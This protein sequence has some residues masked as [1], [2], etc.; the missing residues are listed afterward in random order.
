MRGVGVLCVIGAHSVGPYVSRPLPG[1]LWP[2]YEPAAG[3]WEA[4][5]A[6]G[7]APGITD[8]VFW[9]IRA[10]TVPMFFFV[11]GLMGHQALERHGA[12]EFIRSRARKVGSALF[13]GF[14]LVMPVVYVIWVWGWVRYGYAAWEHLRHFHFGPAVQQNLHGFGHLW[15]LWYL[16]LMCAAAAGVWRVFE[17]RKNKNSGSAAFTFGSALLAA[18]VLVPLGTLS[19]TAVRVFENG[20]VPRAGF[21][22]FHAV[23]FAWGMA[24]SRGLLRRDSAARV[25]WVR[26][27]PITSMTGFVCAVW[28]LV[29]LHPALHIRQN[30]PPPVELSSTDQWR[31]GVLAAVSGVML[32]MG[33]VGTCLS[34]RGGRLS[35]RLAGLG[36]ASMWVYITHMPWVGLAAVAMFGLRMPGELKA[37]IAFFFALAMALVTRRMFARTRVGAWLGASA[38]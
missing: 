22:L 19:E 25:L 26:L 4:D 7:P 23:F 24:S 32:V 30:E 31:V 11:A 28:M 1:L 37:G 14:F 34:G 27:A 16:L 33:V 15:Y 10:F 17:Q 21:F 8:L 29:V 9:I 6:H 36:R 18:C 20:Y 38:L 13:A 12:R 35:G 2:I 5:P 3:L